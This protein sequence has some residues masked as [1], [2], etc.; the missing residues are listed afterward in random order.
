MFYY[1]GGKRRLAR[2]YPRPEHSVVIEPFAGS[3]AYSVIHLLPVKGVRTIERVI[4]V[5]KDPRVCEI[6]DRL[7]GMSADELL[8]YPIPAAGERTDDFLLMTSACS[9]RIARTEEMTVTKRMP[10]VLKRM[11]KQIAAVLPE[12]KGRVTIIEGDYTKAPDIEATWFI[13]PP[14]HVDGRAQ[15]RGMGYAEDCNSYSLD[16]EKLAKWCR[17]RQG[18]KIVCEQEGA[19]WLQFEHLRVARNSI[20]RNTTEV[21]WLDPPP[22]QK[23]LELERGLKVAGVAPAPSPA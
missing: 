11:F 19:D 7:L 4:L 3:A 22:A 16:Y 5:E 9:N 15:S 20:G 18:Q 12:V 14:Y 2:V 10:V 1:Y 21:V 23:A 13:D 8:N 6:W 17:S